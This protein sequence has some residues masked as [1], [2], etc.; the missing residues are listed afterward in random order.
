VRRLI[1]ES[2][3]TAGSHVES[4][5][6][7]VN[8]GTLA[9]RLRAHVP[10]LILVAAVAT[11]CL[12]I[13][14]EGHDWGDDFALYVNQAQALADGNPGEVVADNR[15]TLANSSWNTLSPEVYP[16][17]WPLLMSPLVAIFGLDFTVI[18]W[19]ATLCFAVFLLT[20][21]RLVERR[22]GRLPGLAA[23]AL[24]G[25]GVPYVGSTDT[26]LSEMPYLAFVGASL[27]LL[28]R[29]R[30]SRAVAR[31]LRSQVVLGLMVAGA[32]SIRREGLALVVAL[33]VAQLSDARVAR[34]QGA[35]VS[36]ES[37]AGSVTARLPWAWAIPYAVIVGVMG[38]IQVLLPGGFGQRYPGAGLGQIA[39]NVSWYRGPLAEHLGVR[40][41][42][43][44]ESSLLGSQAL[45]VV[46]MSAFLTLVMLGIV[47]RLGRHFA[48]D[49][50]IAAFL[51]GTCLI[52][53]VLPFHEGRYL[54][55][56][57]PF[58]VYFAAQALPA[59]Y[60]T[61]RGSHAASVA[62]AV[63]IGAFAFAALTDTR[64]RISQTFAADHATVWGPESTASQEMFAEVRSRTGD[65]DVI[66]FQR[67][68][69]MTLYTDRRSVQLL[70]RA[71]LLERA[72]WYVR[73]KDQADY[74]QAPLSL[75][76]AA[77]DGITLAWHNDRF[78]LWRIPDPG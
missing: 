34:H 39:T 35:T 62:S 63:V 24:V 26:V 5:T 38:T 45:A 59:I 47:W 64:L 46:A 37:V 54:F 9:Q 36:P 42:G 77:V 8:P 43:T 28:D 44:A 30:L 40:D 51:A 18:K 55:S 48:L 65:D 1:D 61:R 60:G 66:A 23:A 70:D 32:I 72:D 11:A 69:A 20:F 50:P 41:P 12:L 14:R 57:V 4:E 15:F 78:E 76:E 33:V 6:A 17:G 16:W 73:V 3:A 25:F 10:A 53:G 52:I 29:S 71:E 22:A 21:Y 58:L 7:H 31:T 75:A 49:A 2:A 67:A 27:L 74:S 56:I 68:R 19:L 13:Q